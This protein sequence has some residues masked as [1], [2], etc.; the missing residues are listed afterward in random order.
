MVTFTPNVANVFCRLIAVSF[1]CME[2][3]AF[4]LFSPFFNRFSEGKRYC[5]GIPSLL[6]IISFTISGDTSLLSPFLFS[7]ANLA[8]GL[9]LTDPLSSFMAS[10]VLSM[11][12]PSSWLLPVSVFAPYGS[13]ALSSRADP[14]SVFIPISAPSVCPLAVICILSYSEE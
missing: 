10:P 3:A 14:V 12:L 1:N 13:P 7:S 11:I 8:V 9:T 6:F 2:D 5:F 4:P